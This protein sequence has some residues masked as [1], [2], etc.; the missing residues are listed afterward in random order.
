MLTA[1]EFAAGL[2]IALSALADIY[3]SVVVP[4]RMTA[5]L[6]VGPTLGRTLFPP[7]R[8]VARRV[9]DD[10]RRQDLLGLFGPMLLLSAF[11]SWM[12]L[13]V[14]GFGLM[15][16]ALRDHF[17]PGL[18]SFPDGL[19]QA[20]L[21]L[22]TLGLN[23]HTAEGGARWLVVWAGFAGYSV[24][25]LIVSFI[26]SFHAALQQRETLVLMLGERTG[27]PPSGLVMLERESEL[28][29]RAE[30]DG[31]F[32]RWEAW[33]AGVLHS[34]AAFPMLA[35]F[36]SADHDNDWLSAFGAVLDAAALTLALVENGP[37]I[38]RVKGQALLLHRS[39]AR[40]GREL[41]ALFDLPDPDPQPA[42][43]ADIAEARRRLEAAGFHVRPVEDALEDF[44]RLSRDYAGQIHALT[45]Y[46][47]VRSPDWVRSP[48]D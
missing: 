4:R 5:W 26:L 40:A 2:L 36:R 39:G 11:L 19:Y 6:R 13:L 35:Y 45:A 20:G 1:L 22:T 37:D 7:W 29:L 3:A 33:A 8:A 34:H 27:R 47:G 30:L 43:E 28:G 48:V 14:L 38:Q 17:D 42:S 25:T 41:C 32:M 31:L 12:A 9:G 10:T 23:G 18:R 44:R 46:F 16:H 24:V 21:M 15:G